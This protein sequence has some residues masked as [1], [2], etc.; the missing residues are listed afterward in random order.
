MEVIELPETD[1]TNSWVERNRASLSG[2]CLVY[3]VSQ[4]AGRG[5]R[6]NSWESEPGKNLTASA[7]VHP[8]GVLP[9]WQFLISEAVALAVVDFLA[10]LG[11]EAR[12]KW[13][14]DVYA[15]NKKICGILIGHAVMP[16]VI[17]HT[18][19]G[20]GININQREF[21]SDAPNP[22]S[23]WELTGV[24][25]DIADLAAGLAAVLSERLTALYREIAETDDMERVAT[26]SEFMGKMWR[27]DGSFYPFFDR[28][29]GERINA[30]ISGVAPDGTLSL[31]TESGETRTYAFKEVEFLL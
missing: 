10:P 22:V 26:H 24:E 31:E 30:R 17:M 23:V 20:I 9:Q 25:H 12:V 27:G 6:G 3:A 1:S 4:T 7:L 28:N 15:G 14:N 16:G 5:Q 13:P 21:L 18:V 2:D 11:V 29:A 19:A 8:V